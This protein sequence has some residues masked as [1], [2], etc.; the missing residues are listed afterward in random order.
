MVTSLPAYAVCI[1]LLCSVV[2]DLRNFTI[3]HWIPISIIALLAVAWV[4]GSPTPTFTSSGLAF[5]VMT[6]GVGV[7]WL[8]GKFFGGGDWK[9]LS[10]L[11][12]WVG[13]EHC[14]DL[15]LAVSV[16]GGVETILVLALRKYGPRFGAGRISILAPVLEHDGVPYGIAIAIGGIVIILASL[17]NLSH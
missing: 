11:A 4:L 12:P 16:A 7:V 14:L 1:M 10:S 5:G 2:T 3:P 6:L 8:S 9:L 13:F 17:S 15:L